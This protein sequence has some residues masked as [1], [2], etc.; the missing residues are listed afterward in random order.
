MEGSDEAGMICDETWYFLVF[1]TQNA[2]I[3]FR[4]KV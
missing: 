1:D 2:C 3:T 4:Y